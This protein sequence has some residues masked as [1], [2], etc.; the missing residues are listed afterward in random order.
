M[1]MFLLSIIFLTVGFLEMLFWSLQT[2]SLIKDRMINTFI[3]TFI[4]IVIWFYVV[5]KV[6]ENVN[7]IWLM[8]AYAVGCGFGN[9]LTIKIDAYIDKIAKARLWK[10]NK[11]KSRRSLKKK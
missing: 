9:C 3:F 1:N 4:S 6:A 7:N 5:S 10:R 11:K 2:K 8:I